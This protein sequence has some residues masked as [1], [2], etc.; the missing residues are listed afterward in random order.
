MTK[1]PIF[2]AFVVRT[3]VEE[4]ANGAVIHAQ[5][6]AAAAGGSSN[7]SVRGK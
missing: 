1:T 7:Y 5:L 4:V 6:A 3:P 2:D